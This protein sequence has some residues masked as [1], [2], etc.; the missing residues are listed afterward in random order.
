MVDHQIHSSS[1]VPQDEHLAQLKKIASKSIMLAFVIAGV[2]SLKQSRFPSVHSSDVLLRQ[3]LR[4][5]LNYGLTFGLFQL[6]DT[7]TSNMTYGPSITGAATF[8]AFS[9]LQLKSTPMN[10]LLW[11]GF[12]VFFVNA[13]KF[14]PQNKPVILQN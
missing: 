3:S 6:L 14:T 13:L 9:Q 11:T 7:V 8:F 4:T 1:V 12:G 5:G 10:T 2:S